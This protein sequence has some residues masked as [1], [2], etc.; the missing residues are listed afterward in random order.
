MPSSITNT[1]PNRNPL[2]VDRKIAGSGSNPCGRKVSFTHK[3]ALVPRGCIHERSLK[4][5][6]D[7]TIERWMCHEPL[8]FTKEI[9]RTIVENSSINLRPTCRVARSS[10]QKKLDTLDLFPSSLQEP[11]IEGL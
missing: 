8:L 6:G 2:P 10:C 5:V 4:V 1:N 3:H 11:K 9:V 7:M